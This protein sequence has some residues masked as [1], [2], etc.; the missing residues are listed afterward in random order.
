VKTQE[1]KTSRITDSDLVPSFNLLDDVPQAAGTS[2]S[3]E[4]LS[5]T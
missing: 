3:Q 2:H 1:L 4:K 5:G